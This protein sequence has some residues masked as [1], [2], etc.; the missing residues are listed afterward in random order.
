MHRNNTGLWANSGH[1]FAGN[2]EAPRG[3]VGL[4]QV[5]LWSGRRDLNP[6]PSPWQAILESK[7]GHALSFGGDQESAK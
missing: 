7:P 2:G 4:D 5:T 3:W 1:R 6:L